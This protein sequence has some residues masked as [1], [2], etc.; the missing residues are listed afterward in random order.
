MTAPQ[1]LHQD[2][3]FEL[4]RQVVNYLQGKPCKGYTAHFDV[5][6][7]RKDEAD[8]NVET[9]VQPDLS[10]ICDPAKL[11]KQGCRGAPDWI[12]EV[13]SPST[14]LKDMNTKRGLYQLHGVQEY[15]IIHPEDRW[16]LVYTLDEQGRYG[17]PGVFGMDEATS[18]QRFPDLSIDWSFM[19]A[20]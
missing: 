6:L 8:A 3:V 16:I 7:P 10:V 15:W 20:I 17:Q 1:R 4:G 14:A 9:V 12:V 13:L 2:I 5:R 18:V 19:A 11:D